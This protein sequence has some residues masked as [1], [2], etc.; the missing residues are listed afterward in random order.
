VVKYLE[1]R[2]MGVVCNK[3]K[4]LG[5]NNPYSKKIFSVEEI[6]I[7][8]KYYPIG[9]TN[10]V[11]EYLPERGKG[12]IRQKACELK[13]KSPLRKKFEKYEED[14]IVNYYNKDN[15]ATLYNILDHRT[16]KS[17]QKRASELNISYSG[18][19]YNENY[20][21]TINTPD[22]AYWLGFIYSDGWISKVDKVSYTFG[23]ELSIKDIGHLKKLKEVINYTG[24][25]KVK[26]VK[27]K[28][29]NNKHVTESTICSLII[30]SKK[31]F[32]DLYDKGITQD[33]TYTKKF[34]SFD[35][36]PEGLMSHFIR[37]LF[38]GDGS[39]GLYKVRDYNYYKS[40]A[41]LVSA[42]KIFLEGLCYYLDN[43][44][45]IKFILYDYPNKT[46]IILLRRKNEVVNFINK[47]YLDSEDHIRLDRKYQIALDIINY[48]LKRENIRNLY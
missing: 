4:E 5:L 16:K 43:N 36:V 15:I 39:I 20:F 48:W 29:C 30:S 2:S 8:K 26:D 35:I 34:P 46:P 14:S 21:E 28:I 7:I 31:I 47:I 3:A 13:L 37:G 38:D 44:Y 10:L 45:N 1:D 19:Y 6:D 24:E 9:G 27:L 41:S 12:T 40:S 33:K 23:I 22:K 17:I 25:I 42:S 11:M 32:Y 18:I